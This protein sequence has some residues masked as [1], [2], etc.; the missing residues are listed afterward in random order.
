MGPYE[1]G[2]ADDTEGVVAWVRRTVMG[3]TMDGREQAHE[4]RTQ[5]K[6]EHEME[7]QT[8]QSKQHRLVQPLLDLNL[9]VDVEKIGVFRDFEEL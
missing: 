9:A 1:L 7:M 3:A 4:K 8:L 5:R 6:Q 2:H